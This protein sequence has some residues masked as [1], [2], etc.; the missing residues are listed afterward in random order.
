MK[1]ANIP[2]YIQSGGYEVNIPLDHLERSIQCYIDEDG[3][4]L[5]PDF[6]RGHVWTETQRI[7]YVEYFLSGGV[8]GLIIYMNNPFWT[9]NGEP[10][11]NDYSDMVLVDGFQRLTSLLMFL[12]DELPVFGGHYFHDFE[13]RLRMCRAND[14]LRINVNS[15]KTKK[16]VL[17]WYIQ[18]NEGHTPH[19]E[20]ELN[21]VKEMIN[22][23]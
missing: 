19:S 11:P 20:S 16:E 3:L 4:Q 7:K 21:R 14:N 17:T 6:Q 12:R 10:K 9:R 2:Q 15:L 18:M 5:E 23:S 1:F 8:S 22:N 13:D